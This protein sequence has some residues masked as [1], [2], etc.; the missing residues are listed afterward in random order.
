MNKI[1]KEFESEFEIGQS[2][3]ETLINA[4]GQTKEVE[5]ETSEADSFL[6]GNANSVSTLSTNGEFVDAQAGED[7]VVVDAGDTTGGIDISS[8]PRFS[9]LGR[10][11]GINASNSGFLF[12]DRGATAQFGDQ[13][14]TANF[15]S[16]NNNVANRGSDALLSS[17]A[18]ETS[19]ELASLAV[20]IEGIVATDGNDRYFG[21]REDAIVYGGDGRDFFRSLGG[22]KEL[23]GEN[24]NDRF[25]VR[26][27][28]GAFLD[29]GNG[30]DRASFVNESQGLVIESI[31]RYGALGRELELARSDKAYSVYQRGAT[32][33]FDGQTVNARYGVIN[34]NH[35]RGSDEQ[36]S[37]SALDTALEFGH[38][39]RD[40]EK[41]IGS[42]HNDSFFGGRYDDHF[43]GQAGDDWIDS[44]GGDDTIKGG[45]GDDRIVLTTGSNDID[46]GSGVDQLWLR[47]TA[48][49]FV[50]VAEADGSFSITTAAGETS[51]VR[52]VEL[53][54]LA[55]GETVSLQ[56]LA[57]GAV[58][59]PSPT[60]APT[61]TPDPEPTPEPTPAPTPAQ[62]ADDTGTVAEDS[63]VV[64][65]LLENDT[66][67]GLTITALGTVE[68]GTAELN[69]DG[70]VTYR[71]AADFNG[72]DSFTYTATDSNGQTVTASVSVVVEQ[73]NDAPFVAAAEVTVLENADAGDVLAQVTASDV[74][75]DALTYAITGGNEDG[76]FEIDDT[77][78]ISLSDGSGLDFETAPVHDLEIS[79][80]D[81]VASTAANV[82]VNVTDVDESRSELIAST[83][84][85]FGVDNGSGSV[86]LTGTADYSSQLPFLDIFKS[87]R[88]V[89]AHAPGEF[90]TYDYA[91]LREEGYLDDNG[92]P[93]EIPEDAPTIGFIFSDTIGRE[94]T[95]VLRYE[96]EGEIDL[97]F[98]ANIIS[99]KDGEI[100]FEHG[101][102]SFE[103]LLRS[104]DPNDTGDYIKNISIV[105]EEYV[106]LYDAGATF[107]PDALDVLA[108]FRE[109]RTMAWQRTIESP[110]ETLDDLPSLEESSWATEYGVPIEALVQLSNEAGTDLWITI[111]TKANADVIEHYATYIRDNLDPNLKVTVE[112]GNELWNYGYQDT[113]DLRAEAIEAWNLDPGDNASRFAYITSKAADVALTFKEIFN[114]VGEDERPL[115]HNTLGTQSAVPSVTE[116]LLRADAWQLNDPDNFIPPEEIF[117]S[118]AVTTYFGGA[119]LTRDELRA[120]LIEAINDPD[121]DA[122]AFLFEKL[123]DPDYPFSIPATG[124]FLREQ[125][126]IADRYGLQVTD[127][128][129]GAHL[130]HF[131][132]T[133]LPQ[134]TVEQLEGFYVDFYRSEYMRE[135]FQGIWDIWREVGTGAFTNHGS[136]G[137][138]SRYGFFS[139]LSDLNDTSPRAE[140]LW[141][142]NASQAPWWEDRGGEHFQQGVIET[143]TDGED[144]L[145]GTNQEDYLSGGDG[146]D[147]I[148]AGIGDDGVNGGEGVDTI[149]FAGSR[150]EYDI[151]RDGDAVI[152]RHADGTDTVLNVEVVEF[153]SGEIFDIEDLVKGDGIANEGPVAAADHVVVTEDNN[154]NITT[155]L[156]N[157]SDADGGELVIVEVGEAEHGTLRLEADGSVTYIPDPN[158]EGPDSFTY[159]VSDGTDRSSATVTLTVVNEADAPT[160]ISRHL[161]VFNEDYSAGD[162]IHQVEADDLDGDTLTYSI[163]GGNDEG[164]FAIDAETGAVTTTAKLEED[165]SV[166][167]ATHDLEIAVSDGSFVTTST[168]TVEVHQEANLISETDVVGE[169]L[170]GGNGGSDVLQLT[171]TDGFGRILGSLNS[172]GGQFAEL[173]NQDIVADRSASA[174]QIY[175]SRYELDDDS[176]LT[177][178]EAR[179]EE[180]DVALTASN[181]A[182]NF[183]IV[184]GTEYYDTLFGSNAND[185]YYGGGG[186]DFIT[187]RGGE[188][189]LVGGAGNDNIFGGADADTFVFDSFDGVDRLRD[190]SLEDGDQL[191]VSALLTNFDGDVSAIGDYI[192][193]G[194]NEAGEQTLAVSANGDG[195]FVDVATFAQD[196]GFTTTLA[197]LQDNNSILFV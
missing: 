100:V 75:G 156:L 28:D 97:R 64:L 169:V 22:D 25:F 83:D 124:E 173:L 50:V 95:Y 188:D 165:A 54:R 40:I 138:P 51:T 49:D 87:S 6:L 63:A 121:V 112:Y 92:W 76:L 57:S 130:L 152:F 15:H 41:I 67:E 140:F 62:A 35:L 136:V 37:D 81:G 19:L 110:I 59:D 73:V 29:G 65:D 182:V 38:V 189:I 32:A 164:L 177:A 1:I 78:A 58:V 2:S 12:Y 149:L 187:G 33:E 162:L 72:T 150:S 148:V 197:E 174:L 60:P 26:G 176:G 34:R 48:D 88:P 142:Q 102:G 113:H 107:N 166:G 43:H 184:V 93:T 181:F 167:I 119:T 53:A 46:G 20:N 71:P 79:V 104:T 115:L 147:Y 191:D 168:L 99:Q 18:L 194:V 52:G 44:R 3:S 126:E 111:P 10:E 94:G 171:S 96:G 143:G 42:R 196:N 31:G 125:K 84:R 154:A 195:T 129:G 66:G 180:L 157:D 70:T 153:E 109:F 155:L 117:D 178:G 151:Y 45:A 4:E 146:N 11:L 9:A 134:E 5:P 103:V 192:A 89:K 131:D 144:L 106:D 61:P 123:N 85:A 77:G 163:A 36:L 122:Q 137:E 193:L 90:G 105:K 55:G 190:F 172:Y 133:N 159:V 68:N 114:Q 30:N 108:D 135:L 141:E 82:T 47:G 118:I 186:S 132:N 116:A 69:A 139:F 161:T 39:T 120:D 98:D 21:Y 8:I 160:V 128:E 183:E 24:G 74:E 7:V 23:Y 179:G 80:S 91:E 185:T 16:L 13:T 86:G 158:Y 145:I 175:S 170:N 56:D 14:V 101:S 27:G 127:Y 17:T